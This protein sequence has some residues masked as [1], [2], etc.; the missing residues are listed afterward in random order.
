VHIQANI[1]ILKDFDEDT[2]LRIT[3]FMDFALGIAFRA[4]H[5]QFFL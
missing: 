5:R 3:R 1:V 2:T 4:E